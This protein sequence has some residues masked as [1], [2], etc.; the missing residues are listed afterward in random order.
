MA[1]GLLK[2]EVIAINCFGFVGMFGF[3]E[4]FRK[5]KQNEES[6]SDVLSGQDR[7]DAKAGSGDLKMV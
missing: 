5:H 3:R 1:T 6:S 7:L 2:E 4:G